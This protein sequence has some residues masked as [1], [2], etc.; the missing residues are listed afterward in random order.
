MPKEQ[1]NAS[2]A[3]DSQKESTQKQGADQGKPQET[4]TENKQEIKTDPTPKTYNFDGQ[5][6]TALQLFNMQKQNQ[7]RADSVISVNKKL[8]DEIAA[9]SEQVKAIANR[10]VDDGIVPNQFAEPTSPEY[11]KYLRLIDER[12]AK[13]VESVV[14]KKLSAVTKSLEEQ[15]VEAQQLRQA[16]EQAAII[17]KA[18]KEYYGFLQKMVD[19]G[20]PIP[21]DIHKQA[22][23]EVIADVQNI[24]KRPYY[25]KKR[26]KEM[27][28]EKGLS[29]DGVEAQAKAEKKAADLLAQTQVAEGSGSGDAMDISG[30]DRKKATAD[31]MLKMFATN[32]EVEL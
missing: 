13:I 32:D 18:N 26:V 7:S 6:Y 27:M 3:N 22:Y 24:A 15:R 16:E 14:E 5:E 28:A 1:T 11:Q 4:Q 29:F 19:A 9:L 25:F 2:S 30:Q 20:N 31:R 17:N 23:D 12:Q 21:D 10:P 8:E